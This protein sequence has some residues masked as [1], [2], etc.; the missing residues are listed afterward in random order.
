MLETYAL[1][2]QLETTRKELSRSLYQHDAACRVIARL[3]K[4]KESLENKLSTL[5][6]ST[7][8]SQSIQGVSTQVIQNIEINAER[9]M[10]ARKSRAINPELVPP[11]YLT[12]IKAP[13]STKLLH[14][15]SGVT[16]ITLQ[17]NGSQLLTLSGDQNGVGVLFDY[18][19]GE[20][21]SRLKGHTNYITDL[22]FHSTDLLFT[23]SADQT[24][25]I[26]KSNENGQ[27][28][29]QQTFKVHED[30]VSALDVHATGDYY[31]TSSLDGTWAFFDINKG[32]PLCNISASEPLSTIRIHPD[33]LI[34]A[35]A[36][37]SGKIQ[38]WSLKTQKCVTTVPFHKDRINSLSFS[39]NGFELA[40][41][42]SDKS[43]LVID[44]RK[45]T[46]TATFNFDENV[47]IVSF[48][49]SGHY[50]GIGYGSTVRLYQSKVWGEPLNSFSNHTNQV[51][52]IKFGQNAKSFVTSSL[53]GQIHF[54]HL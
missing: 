7:D 29:I 20:I 46:P 50:L 30:V 6:Q 39:E 5:N 34:A 17:D 36:T 27:Y 44:L 2:Q 38:L 8:I 51:T 48:D 11:T 31:A 26:W 41:G 1:K 13:S 24:S 25:K 21:L 10:K 40:T 35:T 54:Y 52:G 9:L 37:T 53:D 18:K 28:S 19:S 16:S 3:L 12:Q 43:A 15:S 33:G 42:S 22:S 14:E 4:E 45:M 49:Y 23:S 32:V 47:N